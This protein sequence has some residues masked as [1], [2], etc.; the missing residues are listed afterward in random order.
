MLAAALLAPALV[1][2]SDKELIRQTMAE[3]VKAGREGRPGGVLESLSRS[4]RYN[5]MPV[6]DPRAVAEFVR[7]SKPDVTLLNPEP[8]IE[9]SQATI[10]SPVTLTLRYG[11]VP[12]TQTIPDVRFVL[13]REVGTRWLFIPAPKWRLVSIEAAGVGIP[14]L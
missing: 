13:R 5:D 14:D 12:M 9:G 6:E 3:A 10:V 2:P 11:P 8:T 4:I 1:G 7:K